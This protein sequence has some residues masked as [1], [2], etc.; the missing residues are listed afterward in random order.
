MSKDKFEIF[1]EDVGDMGVGLSP[2]CTLK[3]ELD[4]NMAEYLIENKLLGKFEEKLEGLIKDFFE[5]ETYYRTYDTRDLKAEE[6][7][8]KGVEND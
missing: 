5:A 6:E 4:D 2:V 7:Y 3:A 8:Y 1:V